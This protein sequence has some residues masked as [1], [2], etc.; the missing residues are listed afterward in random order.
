MG[1]RGGD[2]VGLGHAIVDERVEL[3]LLMLALLLLLGDARL[4]VRIE[5]D[6]SASLDLGG[7]SMR[8]V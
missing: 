7:G 2:E 1:G 6:P 8:E 4:L 3:L 5:A